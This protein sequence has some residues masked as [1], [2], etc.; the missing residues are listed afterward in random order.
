MLLVNIALQRC[1]NHVSA[2]MVFP[3]CLLGDRLSTR[4]VPPSDINGS[5]AAVVLLWL[6]GQVNTVFIELV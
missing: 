1:K 4:A 2:E 3:C 6:C 5:A